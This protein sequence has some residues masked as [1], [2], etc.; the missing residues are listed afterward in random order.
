MPQLQWRAD[1][2]V[3]ELQGESMYRAEF[4]GFGVDI[5][6]VQDRVSRF[7]DRRW[8]RDAWEE[9]APNWYLLTWLRV[10]ALNRDQ[11][12][13]LLLGIAD[14]SPDASGTPEVIGYVK[15][16]PLDERETKEAQHG[17]R[18]LSEFIQNANMPV[19]CEAEIWLKKNR[20]AGSLMLDTITA[21]LPYPDDIAMVVSAHQRQSGN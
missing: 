2:R 20:S 11:Q 17:V 4:E 14:W 12:K 1:K 13:N 15:I 6:T 5:A 21:H 8:Q 9:L 18:R 10:V 3:Y 7:L 16:E 19:V